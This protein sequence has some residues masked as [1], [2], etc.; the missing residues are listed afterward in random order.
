MKTSYTGTVDRAVCTFAF[1]DF[2]LKNRRRHSITMITKT[3]LLR[4]IYRDC[5]IWCAQNHAREIS[6]R[7]NRNNNK[8]SWKQLLI[9]LA[10]AGWQALRSVYFK[11]KSVRIEW[12]CG[13]R[14]WMTN[15][16]S[17]QRTCAVQRVD[18]VYNSVVW[19]W[20]VSSM[21]FAR[22]ENGAMHLCVLCANGSIAYYVPTCCSFFL[23]FSFFLFYWLQW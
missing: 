10:L 23:L 16:E 15:L 7:S 22:Y 19:F 17:D 14:R 1:S 5:E 9:H 21:S 11:S 18:F 8:V 4:L 6:G 2:Q 3:Y 13:W 20:N 12:A